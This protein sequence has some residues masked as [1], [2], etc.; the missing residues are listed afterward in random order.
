MH[1]GKTKVMVVCRV[2]K[3]CT[4]TID[5]EKIDEVKSLKYLGSIISA[6]GWSDEDIEQQVGA[7]TRVVGG[8]MR[9]EVMEQTELK[10]GNKT[11][12]V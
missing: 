6:D 3:G 1:L 12:G 11:A 10:K 5:S 7:A 8:R 9:K 2:E 4:V